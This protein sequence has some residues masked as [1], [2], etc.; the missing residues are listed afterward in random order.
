F[1]TA[2]VPERPTAAMA[3]P[4]G[5]YATA[6]RLGWPARL[7]AGSAEGADGTVSD[8]CATVPAP[9]TAARRLP[10]GVNANGSGPPGTESFAIAPGAAR[11][12]RRQSVMAPDAVPVAS[13]R[14][15]ELSA[16]A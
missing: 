3:W 14:P 5:E 9:P 6:L 10:L 16:T 7:R 11:G 12:D 8:H 15:S 2:S 4:F 1:Q 13:R